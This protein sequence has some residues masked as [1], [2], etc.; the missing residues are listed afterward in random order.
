MVKALKTLNTRKPEGAQILEVME[1]IPKPST[2]LVKAVLIKTLAKL[3]DP[4][5]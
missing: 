4:S 1:S 5:S 3:R 2:I